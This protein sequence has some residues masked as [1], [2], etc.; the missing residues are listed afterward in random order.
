MRV[1][2]WLF[3]RFRET[4]RFYGFEE[5]DAASPVGRSTPWPLHVSACTSSLFGN[6]IELKSPSPKRCSIPNAA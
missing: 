4:A 3:D 6:R 1:Q 2:R 5:Y